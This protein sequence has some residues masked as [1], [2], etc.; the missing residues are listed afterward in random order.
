MITI[1][2]ITAGSLNIFRGGEFSECLEKLCRQVREEV[3][4]FPAFFVWKLLIFEK[5]KKGYQTM[6]AS[7]E[8][9]SLM[10]AKNMGLFNLS[11]YRRLK[12]V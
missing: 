2:I 10:S 11:T 12:M 7:I 6:T 3:L 1:M 9:H 4:F 8:T 5:N